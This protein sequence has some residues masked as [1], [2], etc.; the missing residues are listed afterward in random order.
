M[1]EKLKDAKDYIFQ[2]NNAKTIGLNEE[3]KDETNHFF[4]IFDF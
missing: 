3:E 2:P 1:R 4:T